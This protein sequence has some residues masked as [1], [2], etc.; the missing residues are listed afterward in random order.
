MDTDIFKNPTPI[1]N[2]VN[3]NTAVDNE[4]S[5]GN[6]S[7]GKLQDVINIRNITQIFNK[8][9]NNEYKLFENFNLD[10]VENQGQFVQFVVLIQFNLEILW[11]MEKI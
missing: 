7:T 8:G 4:G 1:V 9:K 3:V 6:N 2:E 11:Y 5:N 10:I